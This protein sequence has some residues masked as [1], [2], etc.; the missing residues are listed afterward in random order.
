MMVVLPDEIYYWQMSPK[1]VARLVDHHLL[2]N[3][4]ATELM[5]P[6]LHPNP[7]QFL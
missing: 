2:R 5:H 1:K 3:E 7:E 6:R 4:P